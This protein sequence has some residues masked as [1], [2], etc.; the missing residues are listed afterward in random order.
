M[1]VRD[2]EEPTIQILTLRRLAVN[3]Q[4]NI[5][6]LRHHPQPALPGQ[7]VK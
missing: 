3:V 1:R 7:N 2:V 5:R 6:N 4:H